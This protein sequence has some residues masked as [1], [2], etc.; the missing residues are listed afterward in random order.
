MGTGFCLTAEED[1]AVLTLGS[2]LQGHAAAVWAVVILPEQGLMLS[3]SADRTIKLWKAGRCD[4]TFTGG[5]LASVSASASAARRH[6]CVADGR[7]TLGHEDCVRGLAV[8]SGTE[9]FSCSNDT[10]IRRWLVTGEC[11]QVY[12][13]HTNYIY[14]MAVFP[15]THGW[16]AVRRCGSAPAGVTFDLSF[17]RQISS[18]PA[19]TDR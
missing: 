3:G 15:G 19:R 8:I 2:G 6:V 7:L 12:H 1:A 9:F 17:S 4:R 14:S 16:T 11:L 13:S 18:A 10:S 5:A